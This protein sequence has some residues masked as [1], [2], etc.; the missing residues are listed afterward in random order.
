MAIKVNIS[1]LLVFRGPP[2]FKGV[3]KRGARG[4]KKNFNVCKDLKNKILLFY[5][6]HLRYYMAINVNILILLVFGGP[7]FQRG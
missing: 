3:K 2:F 1:I 5:T 6:F 4:Q 7:F